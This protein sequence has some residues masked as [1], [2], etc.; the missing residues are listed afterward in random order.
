MIVV[1]SI[2]S[3]LSFFQVAPHSIQT[4]NDVEMFVLETLELAAL[5]YSD[6]LH[7]V[8]VGVRSEFFISLSK[9]IAS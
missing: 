5:D 3:L 8:G 6:G 4:M 1:T 9:L 2:R 7:G